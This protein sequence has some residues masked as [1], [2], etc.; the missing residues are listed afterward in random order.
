M[1]NAQDSARTLLSCPGFFR[2]LKNKMV[3]AVRGSIP[4][5]YTDRQMR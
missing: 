3:C 5:A 1:G 2:T 4:R